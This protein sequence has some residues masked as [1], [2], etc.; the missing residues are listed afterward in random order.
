L[1]ATHIPSPFGFIVAFEAANHPAK[2]SVWENDATEYFVCGVFKFTEIHHSLIESEALSTPAHFAQF[3]HALQSGR[4]RH[5][6]KNRG[7]THQQ[8]TH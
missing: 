7:S 6:P 4:L 1:V 3:E 8:L 5:I 2:I